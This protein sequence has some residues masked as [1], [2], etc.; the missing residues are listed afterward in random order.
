MKK[1]MCPNC[2]GKSFRLDWVPPGGMNPLIREY[3]CSDCHFEFYA[4][5]GQLPLVK[6]SEARNHPKKESKKRQRLF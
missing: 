1:T 6:L 4:E 5:T 3:Q 2:H